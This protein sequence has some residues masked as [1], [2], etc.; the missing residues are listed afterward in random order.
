M[1]WFFDNL[2]N[3]PPDCCIYIFE[4]PFGSTKRKS[5]PLGVLFLLVD[6]RR[7]E[8]PTPTMRM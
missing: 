4:S 5:T 6:P 2:S 7:F 1:T 3:S 8:L